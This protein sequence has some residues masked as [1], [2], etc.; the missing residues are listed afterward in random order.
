MFAAACD[1]APLCGT[2]QPAPQACAPPPLADAIVE[3]HR[4]SAL[5]QNFVSRARGRSEA[6]KAE[7]RVRQVVKA[8]C[9]PRVN[10]VSEALASFAAVHVAGLIN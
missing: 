8:G 9:T 4:V 7:P 1:S 6:D 2:P 5:R 3:R 10:Q